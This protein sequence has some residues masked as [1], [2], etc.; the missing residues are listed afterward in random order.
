MNP[1]EIMQGLVPNLGNAYYEITASPSNL[2]APVSKS[3][4][5][6]FNKSPYKWINGVK[7]NVTDKMKFGS[8]VHALCFTPNLVDSMY[9][10]VPEDAPKDFRNDKRVMNAKNPSPASLDAIDYWN[11]F[12]LIHGDKEIVDTDD[13]SRAEDIRE[14]VME[15]NYMM[16]LGAC[17]Y[18]ISAFGKIGN[19]LIKGMIDVLPH[20]S[21][22][23]VDL[24]V[25]G[26]IGDA[27]Q[28]QSLV[29]N[30]GYAWQA[31]LYLDLVN[32]LSEQEP[33]TKFEF[34]FVEDSYPYEYAVIRLDEKFIE[35]GRVGYMNAVA[36]WQSAVS[37]KKFS[38]SHDGV[39]EITAPPWA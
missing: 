14:T 2:D 7:V 16:S 1:N 19:T 15:S 10:T 25:T 30:M 13:M 6:S 28:M 20:K 24:K 38:P 12:D 32:G 27:K 31:A 8:L 23:L 18:E 33:R 36:K 35:L 37:S 3:L 17:E 29:M 21:D 34:L 39:L 5:W 26:S 4:L 22:T 9:V 11:N